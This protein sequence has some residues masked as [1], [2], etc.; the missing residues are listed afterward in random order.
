M[1]GR[2]DAS[3]RTR[4]PGSGQRAGIAPTRPM[5]AIIIGATGATGQALLPMLLASPRITQ[6]DS[7]GRRAPA[8]VQHAHLQAHTIDFS[9]PQ[10]WADTVRGDLLFCCL[11][12]TLKAAGSQE[13]QWKVD[14][15]AQVDFAQAARAGGVRTLVLM[16]AAGADAGS[17]FFYTRM[18]G[19]LEQ[20]ITALDFPQL[21]IFR[22][23]LLIRPGSD[24]AGEIWSER[25]LRGLNALGLL[26]DQKPIPVEQLAQA[27][28]TAALEAAAS[29]KPVRRIFAPGDIHRLLG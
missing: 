10:V 21:L 4:R 15:Q 11:G 27:M 22:P 14:Y 8:V 12:T 25:I 19:Q 16:S 29:E 23:P 20:A 6:V 13:A 7:Y 26:R 1:K 24:R 28:L 5:K 3:L 2:P 18:K 17:R 9:Q